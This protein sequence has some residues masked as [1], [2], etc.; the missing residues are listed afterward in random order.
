[1]MASFAAECTTGQSTKF[2]VWPVSS[3][4][5]G[6]VAAPARLRRPSDSTMGTVFFVI[7]RAINSSPFQSIKTPI[8]EER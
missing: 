7:F 8:L 2:G 4:S 1:M 5:L 6:R 3:S